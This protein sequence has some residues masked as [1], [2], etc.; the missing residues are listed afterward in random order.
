[1]AYVP[2]ESL[3]RPFNIRRDGLGLTVL[4]Q[5]QRK[6]YQTSVLIVED[7]PHLRE[8]LRAVFED[9]G[10]C[11]LCASDGESG[12]D[13]WEAEAPAVVISDVMMPH[14]DGFGLLRRVQSALRTPNPPMILMTAAP[15]ERWAGQ[16][17]IL[18]KPFDL[19][20][21]VAMVEDLLDYQS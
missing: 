14:L 6:P 9:E 3:T 4:D 1:M 20:N 19:F 13:L 16:V 18:R 7:D 12:W 8:L 5:G 2:A 11:V 10:F 15:P 21:L 17:P